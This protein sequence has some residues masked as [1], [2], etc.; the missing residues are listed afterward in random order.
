MSEERYKNKSIVLERR[1]TNEQ[2]GKS[3]IEEDSMAVDMYSSGLVLDNSVAYAGI[4]LGDDI[5]KYEDDVKLIHKKDLRDKTDYFTSY[6]PT[7][8]DYCVEV[9]LE[10][11]R[12]RIRS[13]S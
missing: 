12:Q 11:S 8:L 6:A 3:T 13:H 7:S 10:N 9:N 4:R 5:I 2:R 1:R